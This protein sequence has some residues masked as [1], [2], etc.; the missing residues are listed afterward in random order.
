M[1]FAGA[2]LSTK[3]ALFVAKIIPVDKLSLSVILAAI[4]AGIG[5]NLYTW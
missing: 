2:M 4:L 5:W 3:V 1:N